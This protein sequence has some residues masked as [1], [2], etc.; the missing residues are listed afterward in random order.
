MACGYTLDRVQNQLTQFCLC[1]I[2][3]NC[4]SSS[5]AYHGVPTKCVPLM[6]TNCSRNSWILLTI[7]FPQSIFHFWFVCWEQPRPHYHAHREHLIQFR[8][9]NR[10]R[11][12]E[13]FGFN[14]DTRDS[15]IHEQENPNRVLKFSLSLSIAV[16]QFALL[17]RQMNFV[18]LSLFCFFSLTLRISIHS[19]NLSVSRT[20]DKRQPFIH[21]WLFH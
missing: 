1:E 13:F 4:H 9:G 11:H 8:A 2:W 21:F 17:R 19:K 12:D 5:T 7:S 3:L 10:F 14:L 16:T 6:L 18:W 15:G 20:Q